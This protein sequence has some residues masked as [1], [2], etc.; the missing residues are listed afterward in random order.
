MKQEEIYEILKRADLSDFQES[1]DTW[2]IFIYKDDLLLN[3]SRVENEEVYN[4][5][6]NDN[7]TAYDRFVKEVCELDRTK[8]YFDDIGI[9]TW[10]IKYHNIVI[11][12]MNTLHIYSG[13]TINFEIPYNLDIYDFEFSFIKMINSYWNSIKRQSANEIIK[14]RLNIKESNLNDFK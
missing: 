6:N 11:Y 4:Y 2:N 13:E 7:L 8:K 10:I 1:N 9:Y 3:I 14:N 5:H 12:K